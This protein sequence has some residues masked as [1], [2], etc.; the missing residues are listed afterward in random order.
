MH[1]NY[2]I[3]ELQFLACYIA[4]TII[5]VCN[6]RGLF[7]NVF[8]GFHGSAHPVEV[9]Q[10]SQIYTHLVNPRKP[11]LPRDNHLIGN[12]NYPLLTNL[13]TPYKGNADLDEDEMIYNNKLHSMHLTIGRAFVRLKEKFQ[14]LNYL[15]VSSPGVGTEIV[16]ATCV[17]HNFI[18]MHD[19]EENVFDEE[20]EENDII[21]DCD[22]ENIYHHV[23]PADG[24][25]IAIQ[26][27][28]RIV[29]I[30]RN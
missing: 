8:P 3:Q 4:V 22:Y 25:H 23:M 1:L 20:T 16:T 29:N 28:N 2:I 30:L 14:R 15:D 5:G 26:K 13:L 19:G 11:L 21:D 27:R 10:H 6:H 18:L 24:N 12:S 17:L 7:L 9:F